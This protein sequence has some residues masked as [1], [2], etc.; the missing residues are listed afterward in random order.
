MT[1]LRKCHYHDSTHVVSCIGANVME[2][3]MLQSCGTKFVEKDIIP[4]IISIM[5]KRNFD[6]PPAEVGFRGVECV[7]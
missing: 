6:I 4:E 1:R 3:S 7:T 2:E 5:E